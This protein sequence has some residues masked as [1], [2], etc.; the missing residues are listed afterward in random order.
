MT[1]TLRAGSY[2]V[3]SGGVSVLGLVL[4]YL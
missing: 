1:F 3:L 4:P 2:P